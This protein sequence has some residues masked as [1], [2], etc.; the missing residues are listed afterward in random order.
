MASLNSDNLGNRALYDNRPNTIGRDC[1][2]LI[3]LPWRWVSRQHA[4]ISRRDDGVYLLTDVDSANGTLLNGGRI[5]RRR[6]VAIYSG[7]TISF[8]GV[9]YTFKE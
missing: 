7:D 8:G 9:V 6:A 2:N 5:Q 4:C 1:S 3:V